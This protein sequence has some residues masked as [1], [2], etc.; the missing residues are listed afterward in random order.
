L[1]ILLVMGT[2]PEVIKLA[3]LARRLRAERRIQTR[4]C[5]TAQHRGLL[6]LALKAFSL[7]PDIDLNIMRRGQSPLDVLNAV[8]IGM[9]KVLKAERPSLMLVEGDTTT[10]LGAALAAYHFKIPIGHVEA[11]LRSHEAHPFPEEKNRVLVDHLSDLLFAPTESARRNLLAEGL[12]RKKIFVTGN[13]AVDSLLWAAGQKHRFEDARLRS[14]P[15]EARIAVVTLHRRESFGPPLERLLKTIRKAAETRPEL[16]WV[17]PV[18]PNP[19]VLKAARCLRG[20]RVILTKALGYLDFVHL[21]KKSEFIVTDS[22]GIQEEAPSLHKPVLVV[23][24]QTDRPEIIGKG[25]TLVGTSQSKLLK[26]ILR[27][28]VRRGRGPRILKNPFGDGR[29]AERIVNAILSSIKSPK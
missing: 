25:A 21:M 17:Y 23:R 2:R 7:K 3:P 22:G 28:E 15:P 20:S 10:V 1:K 14:I 11:G 18:H 4:L 6:D 8:L 5:V 26:E 27:L 12:S 19:A 24:E 29:A 13:T 9:K 16:T